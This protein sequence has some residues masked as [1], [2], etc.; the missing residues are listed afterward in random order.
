MYNTESTPARREQNIIMLR[1]SNWIS[2][3]TIIIIITT[4]ILVSCQSNHDPIE[5]QFEENK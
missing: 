5:I 1:I 4:Y 2:V 3:E